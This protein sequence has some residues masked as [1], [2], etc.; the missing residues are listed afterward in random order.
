MTDEV[1]GDDSGLIELLSWHLPG[2]TEKDHGNHQDSPCLVPY[3]NQAA[4]EYSSRVL[5]PHQP[6]SRNYLL[7]IPVF[8]I[9]T[10]EEPDFYVLG[11]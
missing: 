5:P 4:P 3:F 6:A 2:G 11:I 8:S 10:S 7:S 1:K 9:T